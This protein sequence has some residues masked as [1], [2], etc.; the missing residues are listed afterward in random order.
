M[1]RKTLLI[2]TYALSLTACAMAPQGHWAGGSDR[3][4]AQ[5][6]LQCRAMANQAAMGAGSWTSV[7]PVQA[8]IR[9]N[10]AEQYYNQCVQSLGYQWVTPR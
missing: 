9:D 7:S 10:A 6:D 4:R 3:N 2:L 1:I 8:A 5:D